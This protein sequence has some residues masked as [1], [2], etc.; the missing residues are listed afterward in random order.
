M[1]PGVETAMKAPMLEEPVESEAEVSAVPPPPALPRQWAILDTLIVLGRRRGFIGRFTLGAAI[2]TTVVIFLVPN[3]YTATSVV[4][5]PNQNSS[6]S[7]ALLSQMSGSGTGGANVLA[8]LAGAGLGLK[9]SNDMY[10]SLFR[11]RTVEDAVIQHFG[12]MARYH[13]RNM[14]DARKSFERRSTVTLGVKDGLIRVTLADRDPGF[15][16]EVVNFYVNEF[17]NHFTELTVTEASQ[18]KQFFQK[19]LMEAYD[20]LA[21]A[22]EAM[23][24]TQQSTGVL[25]LDS[26]ARTL[27]ES[28]AILRAQI[29]AKEVQL[30]SMRAATTEENPQY[31]LVQQQLN[32]LKGQLAKVSSPTATAGSE[33]GI[34]DGQLSEAGIAY[35]NSMR[36][37]RYYD[38]VVELLARQFELAKLDEARESVVEISDV[39][40]APDKKSFPP[41]AIIILLFTLLG[42][43]AACA[44]SILSARWMQVNSDPENRAKLEA[45]RAAFR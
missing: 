17:K 19:E 41:R 9:N 35:V 39:A 29:T 40:V 27:I 13:K 36:D 6:M 45:L 30:Q 23:K 34:T 20:G 2:L 38:A 1:C 44:W 33:V 3:K 16:A 7:S 28:A 32:A 24:N 18:R 5:P 14:V 42:F 12:L 10:V 15:A 26:Q 22:E 43:L 25:Q 8:S 4:L 21:K 37:V 31:V 11:S